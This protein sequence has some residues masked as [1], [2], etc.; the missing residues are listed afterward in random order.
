LFEDLL[1]NLQ[2]RAAAEAAGDL[3]TE[4][5]HRISILSDLQIALELNLPRDWAAGTDGTIDGVLDGKL[6]YQHPEFSFSGT[7]VWYDDRECYEDPLNIR[8]HFDPDDSGSIREY[9]IR[10]GD[11]DHGFRKFAYRSHSKHAYRPEPE[12]WCYEFKSG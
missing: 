2:R 5:E 6:E 7:A 3:E 12:C 1:E 10:F 11:A 9:E 8:V 4:W